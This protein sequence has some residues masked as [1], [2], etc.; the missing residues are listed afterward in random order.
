MKAFMKRI[1]SVVTIGVMTAAT[2]AGAGIKE[3]PVQVRHPVMRR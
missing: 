3:Q 2:L 1:L